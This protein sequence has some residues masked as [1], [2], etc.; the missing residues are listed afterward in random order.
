MRLRQDISNFEKEKHRN[1]KR[2]KT[3]FNEIDDKGRIANSK[4]ASFYEY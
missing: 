1:L 4:K 2:S 3:K